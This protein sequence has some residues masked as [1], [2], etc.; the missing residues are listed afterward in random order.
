MGQSSVIVY[1]KIEQTANHIAKIDQII[2]FRRIEKCRKRL[3]LGWA[4][5]DENA[6]GWI[7]PG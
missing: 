7:D 1:P 3:G 6:G 4:I 5:S 2:D